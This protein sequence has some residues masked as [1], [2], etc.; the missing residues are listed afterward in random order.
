MPNLKLML[1]DDHSVVREGIKRLID[2]QPDLELVGEADD[3][4]QAVEQAK[5]LQPDLVLM[6]VSM[7]RLNGI[8]ATRL[9]KATAPHLHILVLTVHEDHGYVREFLKAGASGYL[10]KRASTEELLRAIRAVAVGQIYVDPRIATT[11]VNSIV[12]PHAAPPSSGAE[13]SDR[14]IE[15]LRLIALGYANKEIAARLDL[16]VKTIE[17]YKARSMEKLGL[18]SRVDIVRLGTERGWFKS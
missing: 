13:L 6:D 12:R 14:E 3:G 5:I 4:V 10:L 8:E 7:P 1:V 9:L 18:K 17:T 2:N 16:S 15:V 11:L